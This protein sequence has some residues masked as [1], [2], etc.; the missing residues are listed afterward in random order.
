MSTTT[1]RY[2]GP[3]D[4]VEVE[5]AAG[6]WRTVERGSELKVP[7]ALAGSPPDGDNPGAGLLAQVDAWE[8][9]DEAAKSGRRRSASTTEAADPA[10]PDPATEGQED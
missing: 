10:T 2:V 7:A 5:V 6:V 8:R 9:A 1:V 4:E 3:F